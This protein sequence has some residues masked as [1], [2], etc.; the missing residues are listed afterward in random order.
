[1]GPTKDAT[2]N[3]VIFKH[4]TLDTDGIVSPG[5]MLVNKQTMI[6][7]EMPAVSSMNPLEQKESGQQPVA[8]SSVSLFQIFFMNY[9]LTT[10]RFLFYVTGSHNV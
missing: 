7:K 2:T 4:E 6:N 1:M 5:E 10:F 9:Q 8:Y 3:K